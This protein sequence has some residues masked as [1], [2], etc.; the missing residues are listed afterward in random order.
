[1]IDIFILEMEGKCR[2]KY[3]NGIE[4]N[5]SLT[6]VD[7]FIFRN[8]EAAR[9]KDDSVWKRNTAEKRKLKNSESY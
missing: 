3:E 2:K 6:V 5:E 8:G 7:F 1:M 9:P 4:D